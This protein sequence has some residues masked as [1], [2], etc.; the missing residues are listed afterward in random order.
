MIRHLPNSYY[1]W[2]VRE[3]RRQVM[4]QK[5]VLKLLAKEMY[6]NEIAEITELSKDEIEKLA[7]Q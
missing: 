4:K 1:E 7:S 6:L 2:G 5:I 3:G